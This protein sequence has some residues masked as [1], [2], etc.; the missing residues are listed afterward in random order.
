MTIHL[1]R[2]AKAGN[3]REFEG[4]DDLR[5][6]TKAGRRQA[7]AIAEAFTPIPVERV[8][9]SAYVRCRETVIPLA[10]GRRLPIDLDDALAEGS[11]WA[12]VEALLGKIGDTDTVLCTHG[13]VI[14]EVLRHLVD[15]GVRLERDPTF[16]KGSVWVLDT[17]EGEIVSGSY[18]PP[19][20]L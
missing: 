12:V 15:A 8:I 1:L 17:R 10:H 4:P 14:A 7:D 11:S 13:D 3:R 5:P 9:S 19:P 6:L 16:P 2:H 18:T 20:E